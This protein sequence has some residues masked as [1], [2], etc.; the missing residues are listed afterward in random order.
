MTTTPTQI[1]FDPSDPAMRDDREWASQHANR[2]GIWRIRPRVGAEGV[3][4]QV[5]HPDDGMLRMVLVAVLGPTIRIRRFFATEA[6]ARMIAR[7]ADL[8]PEDE[9]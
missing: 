3:P 5:R 1:T 6:Q 7:H 8:Q 9:R 4:R 2:P